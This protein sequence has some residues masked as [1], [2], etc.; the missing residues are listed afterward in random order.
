MSFLSNLAQGGALVEL[1]IVDTW[2]P[3]KHRDAV[4]SLHTSTSNLMQDG[5]ILPVTHLL[6]MN[7][8]LSGAAEGATSSPHFS[9]MEL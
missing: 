8:Q 6:L 5:K 9:K 1:L 4:L 2:Q 7:Y 3:V